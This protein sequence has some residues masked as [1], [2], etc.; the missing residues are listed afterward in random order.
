MAIPNL[1]GYQ[2]DESVKSELLRLEGV[3]GDLPLAVQVSP[4]MFVYLG[5]KQQIILL[6]TSM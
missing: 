1:Q 6:G 5:Q 4:T 3:S 2:G